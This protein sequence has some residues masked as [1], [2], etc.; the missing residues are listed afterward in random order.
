MDVCGISKH[1]TYKKYFTDLVNWGFITIVQESKNQYTANIIALPKNGK[2]QGKALDKALATHE[3]KHSRGTA[4]IDKLQTS[5]LKQDIYDFWN[6]KKIIE[7]KVFTDDMEK[8]IK[9]QLSKYS[10]E[11]IKTAITNYSEI[12]NDPECFFK[13]KWTLSEF[14]MRANGMQV[15]IDKRPEDYKTRGAKPKKIEEYK[16]PDARE[17]FEFFTPEQEAKYGGVQIQKV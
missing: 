12:L 2:A 13:Y 9:K 1:Q 3:A 17:N 8:Q 10:V 16:K 15:F 11:N 7:H 4:T 5:N 6:S 14:M